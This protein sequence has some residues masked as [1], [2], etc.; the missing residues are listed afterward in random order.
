MKRSNK[1][2]AS[3]T[4]DGQRGEYQTSGKN[5][6]TLSKELKVLSWLY[7]RTSRGLTC[8]AFD[9]F[10]QNLDTSFR[11]H[12]SVLC[13]KY[14]LEIPRRYVKNTSTG[15]WYKEYWLSNNDIIKVKKIL[16]K[17]GNNG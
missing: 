7:D 15:A 2:S 12:I 4:S 13:C 5:N 9:S 3:K 14:G 11:T 16:N 17:R 6:N 1:K 10:D 8:T